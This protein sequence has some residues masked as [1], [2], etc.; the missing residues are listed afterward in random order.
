MIPL[1]LK[2]CLPPIDRPVAIR[3]H[4]S[5][6]ADGIDRSNQAYLLAADDR[7]RDYDYEGFGLRIEV[8]PGEALGGDVVMLVPGQEIVHR[9]IRARSL[10]NTFLVTERCDQLC[11][12]C[13][14]PPKRD[15]VDLFEVFTQAALLAP[16]S[17]VIGISG[18][19]P[20]LYK[21]E[22]FE[23]LTTA[24]E[25]RPDLRFHVLTNAQHFE[26]EDALVIGAL[27]RGQVIWGIPLYAPESGLH[28]EIV[29]KPGAYDRLLRNL[30][31]L[32]AAGAIVELRTVV[33][34]S[35]LQHLPALA[36][37]V[38]RNWAFCASWVIM[39]MEPI[40][41]ARKN[42]RALFADTSK[43]FDVVGRAI[44]IAA[45][46]GIEV[47]LFNFPLCTVPEAYRQ[48]APAS[49]SDWKRKYVD[50][51]RDC[52]LRKDCGGLFE[53]YDRTQG[54]SRLGVA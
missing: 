16:P 9:L 38:S 12:M 35:N 20:T 30:A 50:E 53:W 4:D 33:M 19:E 25:R 34:T 32:R 51:C 54:F 24:A 36:H 3:L 15:H 40:G 11:V 45:A 26:P 41:F 1:R 28:D 14:Q 22:L 47:A 37:D 8:D 31:L 23:L 43:A 49:I 39:Q 46:R 5:L 42:W 48:Y 10:H 2:A 44:N 17:A 18:G 6:P 29:G 13:S 7:G 52:S 21:R 27:P